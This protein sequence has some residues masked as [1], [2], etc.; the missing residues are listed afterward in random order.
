MGHQVVA[1]RDE[2]VRDVGEEV[3]EAA[4]G[5]RDVCCQHREKQEG[6]RQLYGDATKYFSS[7]FHPGRLKS[8]APRVG[9]AGQDEDVSTSHGKAGAAP[10]SDP[11]VGSC[12]STLPVPNQSTLGPGQPDDVLARELVWFGKRQYTHPT[13]KEK[14]APPILHKLSNTESCATS[15]N[16]GPG[17]AL[18]R[19]DRCP[20][21]LPPN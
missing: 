3:E 2:E 19:M 14:K 15:R 8:F 4:S 6:K 5:S 17:P 13:K 9:T 10:D 20:P 7:A 21:E 16:S 1:G 11:A 12:R 18:S